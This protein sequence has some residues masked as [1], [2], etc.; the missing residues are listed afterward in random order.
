MS[1]GGVQV[2]QDGL[3]LN[4]THQIVVYADDVNILEGSVHTIKKNTNTLLDASKEIGLEVNAYTVSTL[5]TG[6]LNC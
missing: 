2:I 3:K 1:F 6:N 5:G 4:G